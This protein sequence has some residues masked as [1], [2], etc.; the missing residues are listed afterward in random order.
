VSVDAQLRTQNPDVYAAGDCLPGPDRFTHAA[1]WQAR[2]AVRNA[3]LGEGLDAGRL[4]VPRATYTDPEVAAVGRTAAELRAA[5][6]PFDT[7]TRQLRDVDRSRCDGVQDGFAAL[8]VAPGGRILGATVVGPH[9]GDHISEV[10]L[11]MQHGLTAADLAGTMHP[12]PTGAEVVRQ[13]A[14]AY[15]R[16]RIF[17]SDNQALLDALSQP[18]PHIRKHLTAGGLAVVELDRPDALHACDVAMARDIGN[19]ACGPET[20]AVLL[21]STSPRAFCAGG[22][23]KAMAV[24]LR[25]D[26]GSL[27]PR[28]QLAHEYRSIVAVH[29]Q[30]QQLPVVALMDG[31]S[32]G[33]GLCLAGAATWRVV[34][35]RSLLAMPECAIGI[36]PDVGFAALAAE[37]PPGVGLCM[38]LTGW[39]L[40][41]ADAL[42]AGLATHFVSSE[43]LPE[44]RAVLCGMDWKAPGDVAVR[45]LGA[46]LDAAARVPEP[47]LEQSLL[48]LLP[49]V[50]DVFAAAPSVADVRVRLETLAWDDGTDPRVQRWA[51]ERLKGLARGCP[52]T[53][54]ASLRLLH[55]GER[56]LARLAGSPGRHERLLRSLRRDYGATLRLLR[57]PDFLEGVRA[58]L[59][60]K[61]DHPSWACSLEAITEQA[62]EELFL[63]LPPGECLELEG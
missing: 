60:D 23:V 33:F 17:R 3:L 1:E 39:Q 22:D 27:L 61:D 54:A 59:V 5:R 51:A 46:A 24:A 41:G 10:T 21:T 49:A 7:F 26:A 19:A 45:A 38:A 48:A 15:V 31:I 57:R 37:L 52:L 30:A 2:M 25:K 62:V 36:A 12:Y 47:Q 42:V 6:V 29:G 28:L 40:R 13:A 14:Q 43:T 50:A 18:S 20:Y 55:E 53:Q 35:E 56:D 44:L 34:T 8:H 63:P 9:A 58:T 11:C 16:T 32:M 4:L